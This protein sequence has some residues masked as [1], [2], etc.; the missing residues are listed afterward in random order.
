MNTKKDK[1]IDHEAIQFASCFF[2]PLLENTPA[3]A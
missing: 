3:A 1:T 2:K